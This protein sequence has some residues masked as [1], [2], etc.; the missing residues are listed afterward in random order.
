MFTFM[1]ELSQ[2]L[3]HSCMDRSDT[4]FAPLQQRQERRPSPA[5]VEWIQ[6][7]RDLQA[8]TRFSSTTVAL[9]LLSTIT[10]K[11]LA[12]EMLPDTR[13]YLCRL[14]QVHTVVGPLHDEQRRCRNPPGNLGRMLYRNASIS[15][16]RNYLKYA[17]TKTVS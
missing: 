17:G 1:M 12:R 8:C 9:E 4:A 3:R 10:A 16:R 6:F 11:A 7:T 2:W 14:L 13:Q 5:S 15:T